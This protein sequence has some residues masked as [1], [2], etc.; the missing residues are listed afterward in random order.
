MDGTAQ[1]WD[2]STG[3]PI[4]A[5]IKH[6]DQVI[7][8]AFSPDGRLI[9]TS[10]SDG[11]ARLWD[12]ATGQPLDL[13]SL[14]GKQIRATRFSPDGRLLLILGPD[15][16]ARLWDI[17]RGRQ[18]GNPASDIAEVEFSPDGRLL[19]AIGMDGAARLWDVAAGHPTGTIFRQVDKIIA[20]RFS[21]D[22]RL[23]ATFG[24]EGTIQ[25]W[26]AGSGQRVG[27]I[28]RPETAYTKLLFSPS[29]KSVLTLG[30]KSTA[31][32]WN[33][34]TGH[35]IGQ[36][37]RHD[38]EIFA[39]AFS[40]DGRLLLTGSRDRTAR[41]WDTATG[42]PVGSPL[43]H[44]LFVKSVSFSPDGRLA[45]TSSMDGTAKLWDLGAAEVVANAP[46]LESDPDEDGQ[47]AP[48]P[49][50]PYPFE[51][52][53]FS[54]DRERALMSSKA[55]GLA[56]LIETNTGQP[57]GPTIAHRWSRVRALAFSPDG[58]RFATGSHPRGPDEENSTDTTCQIWDVATSRPCSP[59]LP[60]INYVAALAFSP[61]GKVLAS[62]DYSGA[63]HLWDV[64]TGTSLRPPLRTNSIVSVVAFSPDGRMLAA[65]TA[66]PGPHA[67]LWDL[68]TGTRR[69]EPIRFRRNVAAL[70]FSPDGRR[71]AAGSHD[72][73]VRI[74]DTSTGR[75]IG[76]PMPHAESVRGLTFSPDGRLLLTVSSGT[77]VSSAARLWDAATG[78]PTSP[79][80]SQA[81]V[82]SGALAFSPDGSVFATGYEDGS[83]YL[84]DLNSARPIGPARKLRRRVV[85]VA[86]RP[87][88]RTLL[89]VDQRGAVGSWP[90]R[91]VPSEEPVESLVRRVRVRS[92]L[93]L[94]ATGVV[95]VLDPETWRRNREALGDPPRASSPADDRAWH[96][97]L[98]RDAEAV[99]D[100]FAARW[101]L[102]RL[103]SERPGEGLLRARLAQAMLIDRDRDSARAEMD[104][105]DRVG[106]SRTSP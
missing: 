69:G 58:R 18:V 49:V 9:L 38:S 72:T 29:S 2:T 95:V 98:A 12:A 71:L 42:Q 13:A 105:R 77:S 33:I 65:G 93:E 51:V 104:P 84:W 96:E 30:E 15:R 61:D 63:V 92:G 94:D 102:D 11:K 55:D 16:T 3:L 47:F 22:R 28:I 97:A 53:A 8:V 40:P 85:E 31:R 64:E 17:A 36:I 89:A 79:E 35:P 91:L 103:I 54:P 76:E 52:A 14:Q 74:V 23:I 86:F 67:M 39:A 45:L 83:I 70:A 48:S 56:R 106:A 37:V 80:L 100:G 32:L 73:T 75:P 81:S 82:A 25:L 68:A 44:R 34:T 62:G 88:G 99:G 5:P 87:D 19:L 10:G 46:K 101:H 66:E 43:R 57:I 21:P 24:S 90:N 27:S 1:V 20:S 78:R 50:L 26:N 59:L 60:H 4:G 7:A 41:L 6:G